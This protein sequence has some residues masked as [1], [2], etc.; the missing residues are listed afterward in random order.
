MYPSRTSILAI[1]ALALTAYTAYFLPLKQNLLPFNEDDGPL[2]FLPV[3]N[4][5]LAIV[6]ILDELVKGGDGIW[7]GSVPLVMWIALWIARTWA[8]GIDLESLEKLKYNVLLSS[9][10]A[11]D[12]TRVHNIKESGVCLME[13]FKN[14]G[15]IR[16]TGRK[17]GLLTFSFG[18]IRSSEQ[19]RILVMHLLLYVFFW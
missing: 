17:G 12:S 7:T 14:C 4:G 3:L 18:I 13:R 16:G 5:A 1:T 6:V 15:D 11:N 19:C 10:F 8:N 9:G 2:R